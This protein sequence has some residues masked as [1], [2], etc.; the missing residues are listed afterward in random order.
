MSSDLNIL[1]IGHSHAGCI[2]RAYRQSEIDGSDLDFEMSQ[3]RLNY[4]TFQ[5]NFEMTNGVR[6][7]HPDLVKRL[8]HLPKARDADVILTSMMGNEYNQLALMSHPEPYD[9]EMPDSDFGVLEGVQKL[10]YEIIRATMASLADE[11][12]LM[13]VRQLASTTDLPILVL[14]PPPPIADPDHIRKFP[15]A[16]GK[17]L[18]KYEVAPISFRIKMWTLYCHVLRQAAADIENVRFIE[19]PARVFKDGALA[20]QYWSEDP[21]HGNEVY[22]AAL[23]EEISGLA[24]HVVDQH[25]KVS[26]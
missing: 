1:L 11:N 23:L 25:R 24:K 15:G 6:N 3:A 10:P 19:L 21:T 20:P 26:A 2:A 22:G 14:P 9:F 8:R 13:L 7:V 4:K 18:K 17:R 12:A 16:F 5:P